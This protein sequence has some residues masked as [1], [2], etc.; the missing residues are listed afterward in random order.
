MQV[1]MA[2]W[3]ELLVAVKILLSASGEDMTEEGMKQA[4]TLSNPV[5]ENLHKEVGVELFEALLQGVRMERC[6][7]SWR[8]LCWTGGLSI[9]GWESPTGKALWRLPLA[10]GKAGEVTEGAGYLAV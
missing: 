1:Y 9:L 6:L 7:V 8:Q 4:L 2:K 5:L 3:H 10:E